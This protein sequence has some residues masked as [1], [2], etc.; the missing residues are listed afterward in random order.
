[1]PVRV[2]VDVRGDREASQ[3]LDRLARR[4]DDGR[5]QLLGLLD[6][7]IAAERERFEGRG[8]RWRKIAPSTL[9]KDAQQG[10]D[11]RPMIATGDLRDSLTH[12]GDPRMIVRVRPGTLTFGTRV[13]YARFHQRGEG[14]P[15]RT[16]VGLT[17]VQKQRLVESLRD[18]FFE[19]P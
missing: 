18:F 9:R 10:R 1:M 12:R 2:D 7:L 11:P 13:W 16:V 5:P 17:R 14:Q 19:G 4:L 6:Q 8:A 15:K 3:L